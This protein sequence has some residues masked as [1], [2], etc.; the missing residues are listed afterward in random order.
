M[1]TTEA[2]TTPATTPATWTTTV[3]SPVGPLLLTTDGEALTRVLFDA[4]PD[5]GWSTEP[6][7]VLE[8]AARQLAE[9]FAG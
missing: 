5:P 4:A 6:H 7:P 9:Y 2:T 3:D 1:S 8:D